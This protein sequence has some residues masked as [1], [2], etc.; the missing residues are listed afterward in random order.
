MSIKKKKKKLYKEQPSR[1]S[2]RK[3]NPRKACHLI[4]NLAPNALNDSFLY[5]SENTEPITA[6]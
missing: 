1:Q 6:S 3:T 2:S 5:Q 4:V